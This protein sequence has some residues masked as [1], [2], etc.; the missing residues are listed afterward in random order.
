MIRQL[1]RYG[2][3]AARTPVTGRHMFG[4]FLL[5]A[6]FVAG[7]DISIGGTGPGPMSDST[8]PCCRLGAALRAAGLRELV[9]R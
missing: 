7:A 4:P 8:Y 9:S 5:D 3:K 2:H 1:T 6:Q